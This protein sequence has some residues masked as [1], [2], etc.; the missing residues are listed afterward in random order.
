MI[1]KTKKKTSELLNINHYPFRLIIISTIFLLLVKFYFSNNYLAA[2]SNSAVEFFMLSLFYMAIY[3]LK[4]ILPPQKIIEKIAHITFAITFVANLFLFIINSI[5]LDDSLLMKYS[6]TNFDYNLFLYFMKDIVPMKSLLILGVVLAFLS[7]IALKDMKAFDYAEKHIRFIVV[8]LL[9]FTVSITAFNYEL[10]TNIY[11]NTV[12][13]N[14]FNLNLAEVRIDKDNLITS[15]AISD[16]E[17]HIENYSD[18]E[19]PEGQKVLFFIMEQTSQK[20]FLKDINELPEERNFFKK[21]EPNSHMFTNYYTT[22]QDSR[23]SIWT[24]LNSQFIP[25]ECYINKWEEKYG[26]ILETNNLVQLFNDNNYKT[27]VAASVYTPS[28]LLTA[29]NWEEL[30]FLT[31][32][33]IKENYFCSHKLEYQYGCEDRAIMEKI[34]EI[35]VENKNKSLFLMQEFIYGHGEEYMQNVGKTRTEYY[36]DYLYDLYEFMEKENLLEN[37]TIIVMADH[38]EKGYFNKKIWN[39]QIPLWIINEELEKKEIDNLYSNI[40]FKDI[41]LSYLTDASLPEESEQVFIIGQ[42]QSSEIAFINKEGDYFLGKL[43]DDLLAIRELNGLTKGDVI[44]LTKIIIDYQIKS[45]EKSSMKKYYCFNCEE[46]I[47]KSGVA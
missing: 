9:I 31:D 18:Y 22:N 37:T 27:S 4:K 11:V 25:F 6:L 19:I 10:V 40:D 7:L 8:V 29:H 5:F 21:V 1:M 16:F 30:T 45:I 42:T 3:G 14:L 36:N 39:Y 23:S 13:D 24:A 34:K 33:E 2:M 12:Y 32:P 38:G 47:R 46:N 26:F 43:N 41:L 20:K 44:G 17:K 28:L 35:L 15:Y